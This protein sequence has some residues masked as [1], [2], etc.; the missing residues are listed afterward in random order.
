MTINS[1]Q[2]LTL[3]DFW[4]LK[5]ICF[6][7]G[8]SITHLF[9]DSC[10]YTRIEVT[11]ILNFFPDLISLKCTSW[12]LQNDF[13]DEPTENLNLF[14]IKELN[15]SK[16]DD[17]TKKFFETNLPEDTL[18]KLSVDFEPQEILKHQSKVKELDVS[19]DH[20]DSIDNDLTHLKLMMRRYKKNEESILL[21]IIQHQP[22][23]IHLDLLKCEGI[24]DNDDRA[25]IT[26][27][28][29]PLKIL[30][31]NIDGLSHFIFKEN[32]SKL[33]NLENL[34][35]EAVEQ[36]VSSLIEIIDD[37]SK[38]NI[39]SLL[40]LRIEI[41]FINIPVT[42]IE[43][44]GKSF[45]N[46]QSFS[47]VTDCSLPIDVYLRNFNNLKNI[48]IDYHYNKNFSAICDDNIDERFCSLKKMKL[49]GF[50]FGSDD[51]NLNEFRI[52]KLIEKLPNVEELN[53][54][55][56][57]PLNIKLLHKFLTKMPKLKVLDNICMLQAGENYLKFDEEVVC[58]LIE[59]SYKHLKKFSIE[60]RL[61]AIDMD[62]SFMKEL[63]MNEYRLKMRK[64][65][66]FIIVNLTKK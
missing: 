33:I 28:Q 16:C 24:F 31:I 25:F 34:E 65:S 51:V 45:P 14:N 8:F 17:L 40:K 64:Y 41:N 49:E 19:V 36:N 60:L 62:V 57:L 53:L 52:L 11:S 10:K 4:K 63:L 7:K 46:L 5:T 37:L 55:I 21:S 2:V 1:N 15:I 22:N 35:I 50:T 20:L 47:L 23:L 9:W 61:K 29:L 6:N 58:G 26:T 30:K 54:D 3:N 13:I 43:E 48:S 32:F 56:M 27:C 12:K 44:M 42:K 39:N 66:N 38:I 59:V 18:E